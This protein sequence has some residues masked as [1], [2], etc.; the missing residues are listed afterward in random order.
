M[1]GRVRWQVLA[2]PVSVLAR[3]LRWLAAGRFKAG[4]AYG[5]ALVSGT[6]VASALLGAC[7][8]SALASSAWGLLGEVVVVAALTA[9]KKLIWHVDH[10]LACVYSAGTN[11]RKRA[12]QL[13]AGR[14]ALRDSE[15][16]VCETALLSLVEN[17]A[18][19][20]VLPLLYYAAGGLP[21]LA[22]YK[23]I[24]LLDSLMADFSAVN[25]DVASWLA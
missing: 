5:L 2:N 17:L 14:F 21:A 12:A 3:P 25:A 4:S 8:H 7:L 23:A 1:L 9:H 10:V 22:S 15:D 13:L 24:D 18:D 16:V 6:V 19:A 20:T 11:E